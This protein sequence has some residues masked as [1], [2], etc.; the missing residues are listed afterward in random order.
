MDFSVRQ[1]EWYWEPKTLELL[2][3]R[4]VQEVM[5]QQIEDGVD[6]FLLSDVVQTKQVRKRSFAWLFF[7]ITLSLISAST[8]LYCCC[9]GYNFR[10]LR[11]IRDFFAEQIEQVRNTV[12]STVAG[13]ALRAAAAVEN[14][15]STLRRV[16]VRPISTF[17]ESAPPYDEAN[18]P[19]VGAAPPPPP[20]RPA[21]RD[22]TVNHVL[23][24]ASFHPPT[25][26]D[27]NIYNR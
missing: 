25:Y 4:E 14:N 17:R 24:Q 10:R 20:P 12:Q 21:H 5:L 19:G 26:P 22:L 16:R 27:T 11:V 15:Y 8:L 18:M 9:F 2:N 13:L 23:Q 7:Y 6:K 3:D 1:F